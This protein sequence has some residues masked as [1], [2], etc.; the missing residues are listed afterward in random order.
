MNKIIGLLTG[1]GVEDWIRPAIK[2]ALEFCDEI[3]VIV[4]PYAPKLKKFEDRTYDIC[5]EYPIRLL[6]YEPLPLDI[7]RQ[8]CKIVN[9]M[10]RKSK[11]FALDNWVWLFDSDEFY[12]DS[13]YAEIKDVI[14]SDEYDRVLAESKF[15]MINMHHYLTERSERLFR[16][17]A[18]NDGF[19]PTNKWWR[20]AKSSYT[21][22]RDNGMFHYSMLTD[23]RRH[24]AKWWLYPPFATDGGYRVRWL[25]EIYS[26]YD[27]SNEDFWVEENRKLLGIKSPWCDAGYKPDDNGRLFRY[28]G[29]HP[30][31]IEES[32][33]T[34]IR[35]F[36]E[37]YRGK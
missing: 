14:K 9:T 16:I 34:R 26:K 3:M 29:M 12:L 21:L 22:K 37:Y 25:K 1:W 15:F 7:S 27:L 5:K 18:E 33:L 24:E 6:N 32:G 30:K 10:L 36:R 23:T 28:K 2:Q 35:D 13:G 31:F 11:L 8:R 4:A 19:V 20:P 17:V